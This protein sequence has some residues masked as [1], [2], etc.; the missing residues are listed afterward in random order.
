MQSLQVRLFTLFFCVQEY[1]KYAHL[2]FIVEKVW[3]R[4][5][6]CDIVDLSAVGVYKELC[7]KEKRYIFTGSSFPQ[8]LRICLIQAEN[9]FIN[10]KI[11]LSGA[12]YSCPMLQKIL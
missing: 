8:N 5:G 2:Y 1:I 7:T 6:R 9:P 12:E 3:N 4:S 10:M 11:K